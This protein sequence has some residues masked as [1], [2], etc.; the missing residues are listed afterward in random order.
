MTPTHRFGHKLTSLQ[1]YQGI[2]T[3]PSKAQ[4][5]EQSP[6]YFPQVA[7][8]SSFVDALHAGLDVDQENF[9]DIPPRYGRFDVQEENSLGGACRRATMMDLETE[10]HSQTL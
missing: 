8:S 4:L 1:V 2:V 9:V 10:L 5:V 3:P 7:T 6:E